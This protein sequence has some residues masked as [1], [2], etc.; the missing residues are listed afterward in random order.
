MRLREFKYISNGW[1]YDCATGAG[2]DLSTDPVI[3]RNPRNYLAPIV[4]NRW[5]QTAAIA[6]IV[7]VLVLVAINAF[8]GITNKIN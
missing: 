1:G 5:V 6:A 8:K 3:T 4:G 7:L 2:T